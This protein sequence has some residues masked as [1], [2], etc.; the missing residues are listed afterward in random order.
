MT[1]GSGWLMAALRA[2]A[3]RRLS[4]LKS[5][6]REPR[7]RSP[8]WEARARGIRFYE[9]GWFGRHGNGQQCSEAEHGGMESCLDTNERKKM[10]LIGGPGRLA[11]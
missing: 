7:R 10:R 11:R 1:A 8:D 4:V 6:R 5:R 2:M 3:A 9:A